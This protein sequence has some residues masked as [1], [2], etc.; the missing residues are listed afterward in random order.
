MIYP[1]SRLIAALVL[2]SLA[3]FAQVESSSISGVLTDPQGR[4]IPG[5]T[6]TA[7]QADTGLARQ[8]V[9]SEEGAYALADL[10]LGTYTVSIAKPGFRMLTV[11]TVHQE[12]GQNRV[13]NL[14]LAVGSASQQVAITEKLIQLDQS[15]A[16]VGT[17]IEKV[18]TQ[19]LPLNGRNWA[20]L[21]VLAP[22]AVDAGTA[23]QRSIRF[24]GHG[25]DDNELLF[26]G[27][28]D[29][30][31]L[32]Q[33]QKQFVRLSVP[34]D[35]L[36]E[37]RV[38]SQN[39]NADT[40][41][42]AGGQITAASSSGTNVMHGAMFDYF[43]N[44]FFDARSPF[45]G[46]A[47]PPFLL[48]QFGGGLG[49]AIVHN[50]T[51]FYI[52]YEGFRQ[53][54]GQTQ[55]GGLVPSPAYAAKIAAMEPALAPILAA[56]P[57][58][59]SPTSNPNIWNYNAE[60]KQVDN[61]DSGMIRLDQHFSDR[62]TGFI[63]YNEDATAYILPTGNLN[64]RAYTGVRLR[65]SMADLTHIFTPALLNDFKL[66]FNQDIYHTANI[67][68]SPY[69]VNI[70]SLSPI[71]G[72][73]TTDGDGATYSL[74]DDVSWVKGKHAIKMGVE[75]RRILMNQGNSFSGTLT[76]ATLTNFANNSLDGATYSALL[77]LKRLRKTQYYAYI[78]DEYK[79]TPNLTINMGVRYS[80]FNV[81]HETQNR[82]I[83]FDFA[84]CGPGG[85]CPAGS[86]FSH[87]RYDD[88][89][90]RL[91]VAWSHGNT[92]LRAGGGIYHSD[93]QEDD[94][95]LPISNDVARYTLTAAG[96]PGLAYPINT[97]LQTTTG[98]VTPRLDYRNRKD[99][100]VAAWTASVQQNLPGSIVATGSYLGNKG[101]DVL[102]TT[103][104]NL[105]N[106]V[107]GVRPYP[108]FGPISWRG[109]DSNSTFHALQF[110]ARREFQS[111]FLLSTNYMW[112]HSIN[113][114]GIG[115][116]ESDTPQDFFC[117]ACEKASSD[118]D[119][120]Q[121]FNASAVYSLPF[122]AGAGVTRTLLGGWQLSGI[123]T[124]RTGL[125]VN[126]LITRTTTSV[127]GQYTAGTERPNLVPGVS[128]IPAGG[129]TPSDWIN[130]AAF[131]MPAAGT[132]GNLGRN[133]VR[134]PNLLQLDLALSKTV[135]FTERMGVQIRADAFNIL[136]RAQ[137]GQPN[138]NVSTPG[139]FGVI[140]SIVN[141]GATG[142]GTP[143]QLQ[144]S[145]RV[146]F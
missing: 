44:S 41:M 127:P 58:G 23:D 73:N 59:T 81:F 94:Q 136:N 117:R 43:R 133:A 51:F 143:R 80:F 91:A 104:V 110:N 123:D 45:D 122:K 145:V 52:N 15:D 86:I 61:E 100:Y 27:V 125:P 135:K 114:D 126:I 71:T 84:T 35:S 12:I 95:N 116:G 24:A 48:N 2:A 137:Y 70:A 75:I 97:F 57:A 134:G 140:T 77:P 37:F 39:F 10:P 31:V 54:R 11:N 25:L 112:S 139:N 74:L 65:N 3:A 21:T 108:A 60:A 1:F 68:P 4:R 13:L 34:I 121:V 16:V 49:G 105:I 111:G 20:A 98:I 38:E 8:V 142:S 129:Q 46:A 106:P 53:H 128:L 22:G 119:V 130:L 85:Y 89:D 14:Q 6:I 118:F 109:N 83:P 64:A 42:T 32:N 146:T 40:G 78:Q 17:P 50:K 63:R 18:Q 9:T 82:A 19:Q 124:L 120:R 101:T 92:V 87:P 67:S 141:T 28:D 88:F 131:S 29:T 66:A 138:A 5:A 62:T 30:G 72:S 96:S 47:P 132:F 144:L 7:T 26:D 107:T 56:F 69:A 99:M 76:Y 55:A 33:A 79:L 102:T 115:G 113:D 36:S 93:G 90:P 103:Y